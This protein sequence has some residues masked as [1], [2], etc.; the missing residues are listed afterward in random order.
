M[1]EGN[2]S[3]SKRFTFQSENETERESKKCGN[4]ECERIEEKETKKQGMRERRQRHI[5]WGTDNKR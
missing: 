5:N 4:N 1:C 3:I 2:W